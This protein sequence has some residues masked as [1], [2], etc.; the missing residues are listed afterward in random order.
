MAACHRVNR[1]IALYARS[2]LHCTTTTLTHSTT[3]PLPR[4]TTTPLPRVFRALPPWLAGRLAGPAPRISRNGVGPNPDFAE[5]RGTQN[6]EITGYQVSPTE[7]AK[8]TI[9]NFPNNYDACCCRG[10]C[11]NSLKPQPST[12]GGIQKNVSSSWGASVVFWEAK[13]HPKNHRGA[14]EG[15]IL[16]ECSDIRPMFVLRSV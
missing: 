16:L 2:A 9:F 12:T 4:C 7:S 13:R 15:Y 14:A 11:Q 5:R 6:T 1:S 3:T 10:C 8:S